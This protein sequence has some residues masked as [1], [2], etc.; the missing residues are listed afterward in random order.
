MFDIPSS[1]D[2]IGWRDV[3]RTRVKYHL[4]VLLVALVVYRYVNLMFLHYVQNRSVVVNFYDPLLTSFHS[5]S[6]GFWVNVTMFLAVCCLVKVFL[7]YPMRMILFG[8]AMLIM[9]GI[10]WATMYLCPLADPPGVT[11]I[12]DFISYSGAQIS[13]DLFFSGHVGFLSLLFFTARGWWLRAI[14]IVLLFV[15]VFLLLLGHIHYMLDI[16]CAPFFAYASFNMSKQVV[17]WLYASEPVS[18]NSH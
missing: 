10:R 9:Y 14:L 16:F 6:D 4:F 17:C 1:V 7:T 13:R 18:T 11:Y 15:L 8:Q 12:Q 2:S 5:I 3:F